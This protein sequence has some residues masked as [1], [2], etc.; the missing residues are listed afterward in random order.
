MPS[1]V[2]RMLSELY[3]RDDYSLS[4]ELDDAALGV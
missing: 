1:Y 3:H 4:K 2:Y